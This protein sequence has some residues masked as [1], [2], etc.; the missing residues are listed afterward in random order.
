LTPP[1][2]EVEASCEKQEFY[3]EM[4]K[5]MWRQYAKWTRQFHNPDLLICMGDTVDGPSDRANHRDL[6]R[7]NRTEQ[8]EMG[9]E[10]LLAWDAKM[11]LMI[12]GT[13]SHVEDWEEDIAVGMGR[14]MTREKGILKLFANSNDKGKAW[15]FDL[16]HHAT[17]KNPFL[18]G[19]GLGRSKGVELLQRAHDGR[20]QDE[21]SDFLVRGHLHYYSY[22]GGSIAGKEWVAVSCPCLA[23]PGSEFG[24]RRCD[25]VIDFGILQI[26]LF[27]DHSEMHAHVP[28]I[29]ALV[30]SEITEKDL[31]DATNR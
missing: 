8:V 24:N 1:Q 2:F 9:G 20:A 25:N 19:P 26:D 10:C 7:F 18:G 29:N 6:I 23:G 5:A 13:S 14:I 15:R 22:C 4:R 21:D 30:E 12:Q 31:V 28:L 27:E 3:A 16:R 11:C 17:G